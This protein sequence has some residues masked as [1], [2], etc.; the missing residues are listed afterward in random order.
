MPDTITITREQLYKAIWSKPTTAVAKEFGIS[1]VAVA[2][3][4]KKLNV[5]KPK[6]GYWAKKQHGKRVRQT[7]LLPLKPGIPKTYTIRPSALEELPDQVQHILDQRREFENDEL[8]QITVRDTLRNAHPLVSQT[9]QKLKS[10]YAGE[11]NRLSLG[12]NRLDIWVGKD[13][14]RR[15]LRI[16][17]ALIKALEKRG[18]SVTL[19]GEYGTTTCALIQDQQISFGIVEAVKRA[20]KLVDRGYRVAKEYEYTPTGDLSLEIKQLFHG[21]KV[22]RDGK[23]QRLEDCLT[24]FILLL[25]KSAE[26]M[27]IE[28]AEHEAWLIEREKERKVEQRAQRKRELKKV[29]TKQ[30]FKSAT[31]WQ[32]CQMLRNYITSVKT[33]KIE[34]SEKSEIKDWIDWATERLETMESQLLK[35]ELVKLESISTHYYW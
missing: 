32:Q 30:L 14:A 7:A 10:A 22:I 26:I 21:Q 16:M 9:M 8:N 19:E 6:L 28:Q 25:L 11:Y 23:T 18:Y 4:C 24:R 13:T 2:K 1:D 15:S 17:D 29:R 31:E 34:E 12:R 5:P 33:S 20:E 3:I 27:K 35:P